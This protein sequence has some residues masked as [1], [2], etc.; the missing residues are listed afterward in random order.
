MTNQIKPEFLYTVSLPTEVSKVE[1]R[2]GAF[3]GPPPGLHDC[4]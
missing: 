2:E 4:F 1:G 3:T